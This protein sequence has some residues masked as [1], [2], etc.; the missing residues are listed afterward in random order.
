MGNTSIYLDIFGY[1]EQGILFGRI[2][3]SINDR[4]TGSASYA[5]RVGGN[6]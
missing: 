3:K 5:K 4:I 6:G 1:P 2:R